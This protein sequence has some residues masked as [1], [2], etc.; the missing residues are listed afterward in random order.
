MAL[1]SAVNSKAPAA[2]T[3]SMRSW[4]WAR[5][6]TASRDTLR[7]RLLLGIHAQWKPSGGGGKRCA[8]R[9]LPR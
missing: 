4:G 7:G 2:V 5:G 1:P 8:G 6:A 3:A 9:G